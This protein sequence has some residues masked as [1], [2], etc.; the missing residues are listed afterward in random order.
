MRRLALVSL[1]A[2]AAIPVAVAGC[3]SAGGGAAAGAP[4]A[5]ST[6]APSAGFSPPVTENT[7]QVCDKINRAVAD[8]AAAF[9]R[10][11]GTLAGH[12]AGG[13]TADATA[14]RKSALARLTALAT[15][16]RAAAGTAEDT[17]VRASARRTADQIDALAADPALL[18]GLKSTK[19]LAPVI[20]KLSR[21]TDEMNKV[22][23]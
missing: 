18:S 17:E 15:T 12:L 2:A 16:I 7:R 3:G 9:G 20:E 23:F 19:D 8:G 22:C 4:A 21:A 1:A 5:P 6:T 13:N 10:D 14:A 11:L